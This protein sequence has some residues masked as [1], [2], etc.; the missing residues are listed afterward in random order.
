MSPFSSLGTTIKGPPHI[1]EETALETGQRWCSGVI[2]C[3]VRWN[4][5]GWQDSVYEQAVQL[6]LT[7][8]AGA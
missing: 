3:A 8:P 6:L 5:S 4:V 1:Q 2:Y 7:L